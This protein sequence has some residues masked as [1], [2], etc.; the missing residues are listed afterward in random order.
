MNAPSQDQLQRALLTPDRTTPYNRD[1]DYRPINSDP[2]GAGFDLGRPY[3]PTSSSTRFTNYQPN[4][5][6]SAQLPYRQ[7]QPQI[8]Y[9]NYNRYPS[10]YGAIRSEQYYWPS[11]QQRLPYRMYQEV[12]PSSQWYW[13]SAQPQLQPQRQQY[14]WAYPYGRV[15]GQK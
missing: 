11:Y 8:S 5:L 10:D 9:L 15:Y 4:Y 1:V 13:S 7:L 6:P 2:V 3:L 12:Q 14:Y